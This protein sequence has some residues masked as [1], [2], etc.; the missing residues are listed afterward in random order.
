V[1]L[2]SWIVS[3][4]DF[5]LINTL[6]K[7]LPGNIF[8]NALTTN[9][10]DIPIVVL[11]GVIYQKLGIKISLCLAFSAAALGGLCILLFSSASP[12][13]VPYMLLFSKGGVKL[14]FLVCFFANSQIFPAIFAGTA[15]GICN[16]GA[17]IATIASPYMAEVDPPVPM[18]VFSILAFAGAAL[19]LLIRE[20]PEK[21]RT[22]HQ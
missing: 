16:A 21:I 19:S 18:I 3:S 10:A 14:T 22:E 9:L 17:K 15:F 8:E 13:L 5:Y 12:D 2:T 20:K 6:I 4:F 7:Y 11:T 1:I